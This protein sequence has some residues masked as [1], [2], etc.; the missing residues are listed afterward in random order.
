MTKKRQQ[1]S[2][3]HPAS[4][5]ILWSIAWFTY[6][7]IHIILLV[8]N[9]FSILITACMASCV[10]A[11]HTQGESAL[12]AFGKYGI[13]ELLI[14]LIL[15]LCALATM[16]VVIYTCSYSCKLHNDIYTCGHTC[17]HLCFANIHKCLSTAAA[18]LVFFIGK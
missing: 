15:T 11:S 10:M 13:E 12:I 16:H 9:I 5:N 8:C 18:W 7:P 17:S 14:F 4:L 2:N 1:Q 6:A 3:F